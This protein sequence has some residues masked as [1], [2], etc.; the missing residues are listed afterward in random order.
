[1]GD[2]STVVY[3]TFRDLLILFALTVAVAVKH[4]TILFFVSGKEKFIT[5]DMYS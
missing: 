3:P 5:A 1:M 2:Y 4:Y